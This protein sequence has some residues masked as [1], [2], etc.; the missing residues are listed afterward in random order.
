MAE[1]PGPGAARMT[2]RQA[3]EDDDTK[4]A[5]ALCEFAPASLDT[6]SCLMDC[7]REREHFRSLVWRPVFM[8]IASEFSWDFLGACEDRGSPIAPQARADQYI[9]GCRGAGSAAIGLEKQVE[10]QKGEGLLV[11]G[12]EAIGVDTVAV[13]VIRR[14]P[15]EFLQGWRATIGQLHKPRGGCFSVGNQIS[16]RTCVSNTGKVIALSGTSAAGFLSHA[17]KLRLPQ[18][19]RHCFGAPRLRVKPSTLPT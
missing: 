11:G 7:S 14:R 6:A 4:Q 18:I 9:L 1:K 15:V 12:G 3:L 2:G 19:R 5:N 16:S 13:R 17:S 8:D 10:L